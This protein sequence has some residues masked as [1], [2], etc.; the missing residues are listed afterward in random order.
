[1]SKRAE[2]KINKK[3]DLIT[4]TPTEN[5]YKG[6]SQSELLYKVKLL[7]EQILKINR[8]LLDVH[9]ISIYNWDV[10]DTGNI[11]VELP[12]SQKGFLLDSIL[13]LRGVWKPQANEPELLAIDP[14][15]AGWIYKVSSP[16]PVLCHN[17]GWKNN[18]Y[19]LYDENGVLYNVTAE[20]LNS[21]FTPIVAMESDSIQFDELQQGPDGI[22]IK[23]NVKIDPT[24]TNDLSVSAK[25]LFSEAYQK[26]K[27]L[28]TVQEIAPTTDNLEGGLRIVYL[29]ELP[30][31]MY[32]GWLYLVPPQVFNLEQFKTIGRF[33][34]SNTD[35]VSPAS[36][37]QVNAI[38]QG[39]LNPY[40]YRSEVASWNNKLDV[41]V[42][43]HT[44]PDA[45]RNIINNGLKYITYDILLTPGASGILACV[46]QDGVHTPLRITAGEEVEI[47]TVAND[48]ITF[49]S[50]GEEVT[51]LLPNVWYK[52][53]IDYTRFA[54]V[55]TEGPTCVEFSY[56]LGD[57]YLNSVRYYL[58]EGDLNLAIHDLLIE[59]TEEVQSKAS[60]EVEVYGDHDAILVTS[61]DQLQP[62]DIIIITNATATHAMGE[63]QDTNNR[64]GIPTENIE[65]PTTVLRNLSDDIEDITIV[66]H[67]T[68]TDRVALYVDEGY[69]YAPG[70]TNSLKSKSEIT[71]WDIS[72]IESNNAILTSLTGATNNLIRYNTTSTLFSCY[73]SGQTDVKIFK[74]VKP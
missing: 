4:T 69:L 56:T 66:A 58:D 57:I 46:N 61:F 59:Q 39:I 20:G 70:S 17:I 68:L 49:Y 7:H 43:A 19:A 3:P 62:G 18:D 33:V 42:T 14:Q 9:R 53:K 29:K 30:P 11:V 50:H 23:A 21:L 24:A 13:R 60:M 47:I 34:I 15:R 28:L 40:L 55:Y 36:Y 72:F 38:V 45:E 52:V 67:P 65:I 2:L 16:I 74:Y 32:D 37:T 51:L 41:E 5:T 22:Q 25:G 1:M 35:A 71:Y 8:Y 54:E 44:D 27:S 10:D 64:K 31:T 6:L 12:D 63:V 26:A 48:N 73:K